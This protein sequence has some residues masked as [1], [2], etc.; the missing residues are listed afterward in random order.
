MS[1]PE[2]IVFVIKA[3][4]ETVE[5]IVSFIG[6]IIAYVTAYIFSRKSNN[7]IVFL[8]FSL[9]MLPCLFAFAFVSKAIFDSSFAKL[10][11]LF[12][13]HIESAQHIIADL[14]FS[15]PTVR[16]MNTTEL[17]TP[18]N[19][20]VKV[21]VD[22]REYDESLFYSKTQQIVLYISKSNNDN[23][24]IDLEL[25]VDQYTAWGPWIYASYNV[26]QPPLF[27]HY[28]LIEIEDLGVESKIAYYQYSRG[29]PI[30]RKVPVQ[31]G[32]IKGK[33]A[34]GYITYSYNNVDY[35]LAEDEVWKDSG[36]VSA[37]VDIA[38]SMDKRYVFQYF[39]TDRSNGD[40]NA[41]RTD[42][43]P[44]QFAVFKKETRSIGII[45]F[46]SNTINY[47]SG[48]A[49]TFLPCLG[50][51]HIIATASELCAYEEVKVPV[52][53]DVY[54]YRYRIREYIND[55]QSLGQE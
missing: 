7:K 27:G 17:A 49:V 6:I 33:V 19:Y 16:Y 1:V 50:E 25:N 44:V 34:C 36:L 52:Y 38:D 15:P 2:I 28:N 46:E 53:R 30:Y 47:P 18:D 51:L 11:I 39:D 8:F 22:G 24:N 55:D 42:V 29:E 23:K 37:A 9:I 21:T 14:G 48:E 40:E 35:A 20:I 43:P 26:D 32:T 31:V 10:P 4:S 13:R 41:S 54:C 45:D 12:G 5:G 3:T